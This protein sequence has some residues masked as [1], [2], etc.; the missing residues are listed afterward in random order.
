MKASDKTNPNV[1]FDFSAVSK[2]RCPC[3]LC[4][5]NTRVFSVCEDMVGEAIENIFLMKESSDS[6]Y[7]S[8]FNT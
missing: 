3:N 6:N 2:V 7:I 1:R 4:G 5:S 8:L